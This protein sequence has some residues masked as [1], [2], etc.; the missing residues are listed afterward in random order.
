MICGDTPSYGWVY[1]W[2][3]RWVGGLEIDWWGYIK[4]VKIE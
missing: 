2:L 3:G 4:S 1:R